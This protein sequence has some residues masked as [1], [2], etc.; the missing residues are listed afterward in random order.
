MKSDYGKVRTLSHFSP[1]LGS[2]K[3]KK[4]DKSSRW[5]VIL[6]NDN[7]HKF[8]DVV[9]WLQNNAGCESEFAIKICHVCQNQGRA[10]CFQGGKGACHEVAAALRNHGLQVEVD[11]Y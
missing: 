4:P 10:V 3:S 6:Y 2:S 8:D 5:R 7:R 1:E 9:E 11:D